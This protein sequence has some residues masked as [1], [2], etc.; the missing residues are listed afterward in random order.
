MPSR[1]GAGRP[2]KGKGW[3]RL[4]N[5]P[6]GQRRRI[7][8]STKKKVEE[9]SNALEA[10]RRDFAKLHPNVPS[11]V[12]V[13]INS[14]GSVD[15]ELRLDG[16]PKKLRTPTLS[17]HLEKAARKNIVRLKA[18]K[19]VGMKLTETW[20]QGGVIFGRK[21]IAEPDAYTRFKGM[22]MTRSFWRRNTHRTFPIIFRT[23]RQ[24]IENLAKHKREK[25]VQMF[26]RLHWNK[27]DE[28]PVQENKRGMGR[29]KWG[30][31]KGKPKGGKKK[32]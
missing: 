17:L 12:R 14:D 9:I 10:T 8:G 25:P 2:G 13:H 18:G 7:V 6:G 23:H 22:L 29:D 32:K 19:N 4:T 30:K 5:K 3:K 27:K 20:M 16:I 11:S 1:K 28:K 24:I 26:I 15:G 21:G 31:P